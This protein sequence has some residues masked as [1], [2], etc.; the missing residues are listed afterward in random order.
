MDEL[1]R[2]KAAFARQGMPVDMRQFERALLIPDDQPA[3]MCLLALPR[4]G[5]RAM[6][7]DRYLPAHLQPPSKSATRKSGKKGVKKKKK[8]IFL[9]E[10][11]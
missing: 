11:A 4:H 3:Q 1:A 9:L 8:G 7:L 6:P 2:I 5:S 10:M